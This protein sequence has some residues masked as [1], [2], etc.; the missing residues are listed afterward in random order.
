MAAQLRCW[1]ACCVGGL[2]L[3]VVGAHSCPT[4]QCTYGSLTLQKKN[5][6]ALQLVC[7]KRLTSVQRSTARYVFLQVPQWRAPA[8]LCRQRQRPAGPHPTQRQ[9]GLCCLAMQFIEIIATR[10][11][12]H[13]QAQRS[14]CHCRSA[15]RL[16]FYVAAEPLLRQGQTTSICDPKARHHEQPRF[17]VLRTARLQLDSSVEDC[18]QCVQRLII[19]TRLCGVAPSSR[20]ARPR[21]SRHP[22]QLQ[23]LD[24]VTDRLVSASAIQQAHSNQLPVSAGSGWSTAGASADRE[25]RWRVLRCAWQHNEGHG[26]VEKRLG[27]SYGAREGGSGLVAGGRRLPPA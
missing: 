17:C 4:G 27:G 22:Q 3:R 23:V 8:P 14:R 26:A 2:R 25:S 21:P 10:R 24:R 19:N 18:R 16:L 7:H 13:L 20:R 5:S 12:A 1:W 15:K 11:T 6:G 9:Q